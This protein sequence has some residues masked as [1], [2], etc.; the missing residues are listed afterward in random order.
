MIRRMP[1]ITTIHHRKIKFVKVPE[2]PVKL[3]YLRN[4]VTQILIECLRLCDKPSNWYFL[5]SLKSLLEG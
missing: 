5:A 4:F 1:V 3:S 2:T